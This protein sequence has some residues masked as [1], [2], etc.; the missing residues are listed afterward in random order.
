MSKHAANDLGENAPRFTLGVLPSG[1]VGMIAVVRDPGGGR[2]PL[3]DESLPASLVERFD[4]ATA[5]GMTQLASREWEKGLSPIAEFW[6]HFSRQYFQ[7]LCREAAQ[8]RRG[9]HSPE[10]PSEQQLDELLQAAPPMMGLEYL[11]S[12]SFRQLWN[13]LD[14]FTQSHVS[15]T[16]SDTHHKPDVAEYLHSLDPVW[17][18]VGRVTFHL[19]ENKKNPDR[20]FAF[21]ATY[22][23][24]KAK[25]G[26]LNHIP[27]AAALKQSIESGDSARLDQL[28]EP[29]SRAAR[30]CELV[31]ELLE[32][33]ALFSP[34][35]WTIRHAFEFLSSVPKLEQAG[36]IV[37][38]PNWWNASR[39]PRPQVSVRLGNKKISALGGAETLDFN[40]HVALDGEP[41]NEAEIQTLRA[42]REGLA[43]LRGQ[44]V[45]VDEQRLQ[46][47][48]THWQTL[49]AQHAGGLGF[50]EGMRLLS[51]AALA[52]D[53]IDDPIQQWTRIE[54]GAWLDETLRSL[55][56]PMGHIELEIPSQLQAT[57]RPYQAE[58][59]RWLWFAHQIGLGVCLADDMGLGKTI[60]VIALLLRLKFPSDPPPRS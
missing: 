17:N 56:D 28:L 49:A 24:G 32:S 45:Q 34:Q 12:D 52:G 44:W 60:Q 40:V 58:G 22:T 2:S 42:A 18:L 4:R 41:L 50:L 14:A 19:A 27:L 53:P 23:D 10:P 38:V 57:L 8:K 25:S 33:R 51:G 46:S 37:R 31:Q 13:S 54:P 47:A 55:R 7:A 16:S 59:L 39:P 21:L 30:E 3:A 1:T 9:W 48:L 11:H 6:R 5:A 43:L 26:S 29:V 20:P 15:V 36:V 35:A